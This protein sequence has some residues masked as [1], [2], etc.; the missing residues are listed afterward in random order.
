MGAGLVSAVAPPEPLLPID[1]KFFKVLE[2][3]V[4]VEPGSFAFYLSCPST[5]AEE[6]C[7]LS[8]VTFCLG[9]VLGLASAE[10]VFLGIGRY[11]F[12]NSYFCVLASLIMR[13][14]ATIPTLLAPIKG[15]LA[16]FTLVY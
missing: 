5:A 2:S 1:T 10:G 8:S 14:W 3:V 4:V 12:I 15:A 11:C 9:K 7:A 16:C 13:E 6:P